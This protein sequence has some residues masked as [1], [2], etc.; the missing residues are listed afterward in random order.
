MAP[1]IPIP[2]FRKRRAGFVFGPLSAREHD[3]IHD[4]V[5]RY[6]QLDWR[7][8]TQYRRPADPGEVRR[9]V[10]RLYE[11]AGLPRPRLVLLVP[12]PLAMTVVGEVVAELFPE[13]VPSGESTQDLIARNVWQRIGPAIARIAGKGIR[14][15]IE[16]ALHLSLR[17]Q[18]G[19]ERSEVTKAIERGPDGDRSR[20]LAGIESAIGELLAA[21]PVA[22]GRIARPENEDRK[23]GHAAGWLTPLFDRLGKECWP[24]EWRLASL[25]Q[26]GHFRPAIAELETWDVLHDV[27]GLRLPEPGLIEVWKAAMLSCAALLVYR[28]VCIALDFPEWLLGDNRGFRHC[29]DG[30]SVRWRDGWSLYHQHGTSVPGWWI[31]HPETATPAKIEAEANLE[32]RQRMIERY[33]VTR[34]ALD[35]GVKVIDQAG[36]DHPI[37]GL[38]GS[39]LLVRD[40][41]R[42]PP[43][44]LVECLNS[45]A[46]PD[47]SF[48]TYHIRV[49]PLA[50]GGQAGRE[51]LAAMASTWRTP[52]GQPY[53]ARPEDYQPEVET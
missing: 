18:V 19:A 7:T 1:S 32:V 48:K 10:E 8:K 26:V 4:R 34:Y 30:P 20:I 36:L 2:P 38:R 13:D 33:G 44:V 52:T 41:G 43:I 24:Q 23:N 35:A 21:L 9:S 14:S 6:L 50:Y 40:Q 42:E 45:T 11:V 27:L 17:T 39:R 15:E 37:K 25:H 51:V 22:G 46:E 53:F 5:A 47:G 16:A 3:A 12:S 28:D 31:E 29:E 49:D